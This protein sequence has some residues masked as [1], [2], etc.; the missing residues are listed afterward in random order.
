MRRE[1]LMELEL[2]EELERVGMIEDETKWGW[3]G[4]QKRRGRNGVKENGRNDKRGMAINR[5]RK[6]TGRTRF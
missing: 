4:Y 5:S 3:G 2:L 6:G 1:I